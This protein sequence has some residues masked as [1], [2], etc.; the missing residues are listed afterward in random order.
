M[1]SIKQDYYTLSEK[2]IESINE[3]DKI[4]PKIENIYFYYGA[5]GFRYN[6]KYLDKLIF[7]A[8]IMT[9]I[10]SMSKN[11]LPMGIMITGD[12]YKNLYN[13]I[14]I[15]SENGLIISKEEEKYYEELINSNNIKETIKSIF[16][17]LKP[18]Q[19]KCIIIIGID[20]R[21]SSTKLC[22][23]LI[24][25]LQCIKNCSFNLYNNTSCPNLYFLTL[26]NQMTFQKIGL[27]Y[28]MIFAPKDNYLIYLNNSFN[29]FHSYYN[30]IFKNSKKEN[31]LKY[32]NEIS[33]DCSKGIGSLY[34]QQIINILSNKENN[35][36]LKINFIND[37]E[38]N[39]IFGFKSN[40][41]NEISNYKKEI[42]S[43]VIK[44]VE[45]SSN[46][47]F[48]IYYINNNNLE[49]N[50]NDEEIKII[51]GEKIIILYCRMLDFLVNNFS[52][53][54]KNKYNE[55]IKMGIITSLYCN[56]A[57]I[58]FFENNLKDNYQLLLVKTGIK[59]L[60]RESK[61]FDISIC[62]EYNG[63]GTI[64]ISK[65]LSV[66]F[67]K[68]SSLIETSKDSQ[69]IELF[70]LF[71]SLFNSTTSDG[72][73]NLLIIESILNKMNL[74]INDVYNFYEDIPFKIFDIEVKDK[75]KF[76]LNDDNCKLIEPNDLKNKF[77][78]L[79]NKY[80]NCRILIMPSTVENC[81]RIYVES[82]SQ[83]NNKEIED[84]ILKY[85]KEGDYC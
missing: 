72:I 30:M 68:L 7:R 58:S 27:K 35:F 20:N 33:I 17:K 64:Y 41:K 14:K 40:L 65:E 3:I 49:L 74:S 21:K 83:D 47:D 42:Y 4:Y 34:K 66:K 28:K 11:G 56:K 29:K 10:L 48:L 75:N 22:D 18:I 1:E 38:I 67:G 32:E 60:Q 50:K 31:D 84:A 23:I 43:S 52:N 6:E 25:G 16:S 57:F 81:L 2:E 24:K 5:N 37:N 39:N 8:G 51:R 76:V 59:N 82:K 61:Q 77:E 12:N 71:I 54:L 15:S 45:L 70:Q 53:G 55:M 78:E 63:E 9:S 44:N 26:L 19:G 36:Q 46:L 13:E 79:I 73:A 85:L 69:I 62:Y 80:E